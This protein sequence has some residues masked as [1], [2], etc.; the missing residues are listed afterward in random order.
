MDKKITLYVKIHNTTGLMY[1]GKTSRSDVEKYQGSGV[2]W[3]RH[4]HKYGY[5]CRTVII[6]AFDDIELCELVALEFSDKFNIVESQQWANLI[7]ENGKDGAPVGHKGHI[8]NSEQLE[9]M[10]KASVERWSDAEYRS[11]MVKIHQCRVT[12]EVRHNMSLAAMVRWKCPVSR[13]QQRT[14]LLGLWED[15]CFREAA[16]AASKRP[17]SDSHKAS[18]SKSLT[19]LT[20]SK[21]HR[22]S[23]AYSKLNIDKTKFKSYMEFV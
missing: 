4:I 16:V 3:K 1:F 6:G 5:D 11:R 15:A 18:I 23:L 10:S 17:K 9:K 2:W 7:S 12:D 14:V 19:G 20:K 8:F 22:E 21:E 13:Q